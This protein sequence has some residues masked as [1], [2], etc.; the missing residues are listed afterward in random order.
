MGKATGRGIWDYMKV[1]DPGL[2]LGA[3]EKRLK[4]YRQNDGKRKASSRDPGRA[5]ASMRGG[6]ASG[7]PSAPTLPIPQGKVIAQ[8]HICAFTLQQAVHDCA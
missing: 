7:A 4:E 3:V 1:T 8:M 2:S 5:L 6:T